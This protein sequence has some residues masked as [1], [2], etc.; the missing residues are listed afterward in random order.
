MALTT[1][2]VPDSFTF[3]VSSVDLTENAMTIAFVQTDPSPLSLANQTPLWV[4]TEQAT[5]D[6]VAV[7]PY[8]ALMV[9]NTVSES[10][11]EYTI[12]LKLGDVVY[13]D[14]GLDDSNVVTFAT[15]KPGDTFTIGIHTEGE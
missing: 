5:E 13:D 2:Q 8:G 11:T 15:V 7:L 10:A 4:Q 12:E 6:G 9:N 14:G 3:K 1:I